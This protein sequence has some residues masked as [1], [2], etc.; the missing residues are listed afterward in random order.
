MN[1]QVRN[2]DEVIKIES[3]LSETEP[4]TAERQGIPTSTLVVPSLSGIA[5]S[6]WGHMLQS[7][8]IVRNAAVLDI[9]W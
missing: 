1:E 2:E 4:H 9:G 6:F 7:D 5:L 3:A 8:Q